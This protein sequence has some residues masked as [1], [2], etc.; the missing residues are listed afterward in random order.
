MLHINKMDAEVSYDARIQL[1][2]LD[3]FDSDSYL[4]QKPLFSQKDSLALRLFFEGLL[5]KKVEFEIIA[6]GQGI[7]LEKDNK[8][9]KEPNPYELDSYPGNTP[10]DKATERDKP[11]FKN[12]RRSEV[13]IQLNRGIVLEVNSYTD[14]VKSNVR[15][16]EPDILEQLEKLGTTKNEQ[17]SAMRTY[18]ILAKMKEEL[19]VLTGQYLSRPEAKL[20]I[21]R[22]NK[23]LLKTKIS[24]GKSSIRAKIE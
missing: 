24:I 13:Y 18:A 15:I 20:V 19:N 12:L 23:E 21:D 4:L 9:I 14:P 3:L 7:G 17:L 10:E 2:F 1:E 6:R 11:E 8:V 5:D 16:S 22:L